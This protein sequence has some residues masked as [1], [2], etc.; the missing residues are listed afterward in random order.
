[1]PIWVKYLPL[2]VGVAGIALAYLMYM[3]APELPGALA[4]GFHRTHHFL[5]RKWYF[6]E[7][8]DRLFVKPAFALGDGFW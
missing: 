6:D 2:F 7:I 8:Y 4:N 1:M 3:F 5:V